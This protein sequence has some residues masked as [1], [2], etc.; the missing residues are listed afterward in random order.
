M[1]IESFEFGGTVTTQSWGS[2]SAVSD[3]KE[4]QEYAQRAAN[5]V[6]DN[7]DG[8]LDTLKGEGQTSLDAALSAIYALEN[9][10]PGN[11]SVSYTPPDY[12]K[13]GYILP[14]TL[15]F[16]DL[17]QTI[18]TPPSLTFDGTITPVEM[19]PIDAPAPVIGDITIGEPPS[20]QDLGGLPAEPVIPTLRVPTAPTVGELEALVLQVLQPPTLKE[21]QVPEFHVPLLPDMPM[22]DAVALPDLPQIT[23]TITVEPYEP[24]FEINEN[25][26]LLVDG[27]KLIGDRLVNREV[28]AAVEVVRARGQELDEDIIEAQRDYAR[29]RAALLN[30][31]EVG[32]FTMDQILRDTELSRALVTLLVQQFGQLVGAGLSLARAEFEA[33]VIAAEAQITLLQSMSSLYN[34]RV[35][36]LSVAK[37]LYAAQLEARLAR[38]DQWKAQV[39]AEIAKTRLNAQLGQNYELVVQAITQR[40]DL[41]AAEVQALLTSVEAYKSR[42]QAVQAEADIARTS[43]QAYGAT[44]ESYVA[45]LTAFKAKFEA[46]AAGVRAVTAQNALEQA[47]TQISVAELQAAGAG[48]VNSVAAIELDSERLKLQ[49]Q[50]QAAGYEQ[51][52][53]QNTIESIKAQI[54]A[55]VGRRDLAVWAANAQRAGTANEAI[56]DNSQ[57]AARYYDSASN[58]VFRASEQA[59]RAVS[60]AVNAAATAQEAA[61][62]TAASVAQGAYSALHVSASLS[63]S[64][65]IT[66]QEDRSDRAELRFSDMLNYSEQRTQTISA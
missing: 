5:E 28:R 18:T 34:A 7:V 49:A 43:I 44:T 4:G 13:A 62:K 52:K 14:G 47:K 22:I 8:I 33:Q 57:A 21:L 60:A 30:M 6:I 42:M 58:S 17:D 25:P 31:A 65:R 11:V 15:S 1:G 53:L 39:E 55:D 63:G 32:Q 36:A 64:G 46:Y 24:W 66:A 45:K 38:L 12:L 16:A 27:D 56:S 61:G 2:R 50:K 35:L 10:H 41:Y 40:A 3:V 26:V 20:V 37:D 23:G 48:I 59:F 54:E 9:F 29:E 19:P 51:V